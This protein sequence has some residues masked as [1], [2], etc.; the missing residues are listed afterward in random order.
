MP[1]IAMMYRVCY[2]FDMGEERLS[3]HEI[4]KRRV[5]AGIAGYDVPKAIRQFGLVS[6]EQFIYVDF[7]TRHYRINL[8]DGMT[9]WASGS[10]WIEAGFNETLTIFDI[11]FYS[12]EDAS[13]S[14]TYTQIQNL[15]RVQTGSV[16]AGKGAYRET[17][18][19]LDSR[20]EAFAR[21]CEALGGTPAGKGDVSYRIPVFQQIDMLVQFWCSDEDFPA[22]LQFL[23]DENLLQFMHYETT[24]YVSNHFMELIGL[25]M[26]E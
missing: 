20:T 5:R 14:G 3:N 15:S 7:M 6:D 1:S 22:S 26:K 25:N 23:Y 8:K 2:T 10:D 13:L 24:W 21:A 9:E 16:Y 19:Y 11:L 17:E 18:A 4:T 12:Q